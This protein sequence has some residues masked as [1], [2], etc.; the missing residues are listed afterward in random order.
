MNRA[1]APNA[2][3]FW[4]KAPCPIASGIDLEDASFQFQCARKD[5]RGLISYLANGSQHVEVISRIRAAANLPLA[6]KAVVSN[7][8]CQFNEFRS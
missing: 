7:S 3:C 2:A 4:R 5:L 1:N 6:S 8:L